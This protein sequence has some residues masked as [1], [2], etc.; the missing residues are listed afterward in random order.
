MH[1]LLPMRTGSRLRIQAPAPTHELSPIAS[2]HGQ[3]M[4][5]SC[6]MRTPDPTSAPKSRRIV[7]LV[8]AG[9]HH[10]LNTSD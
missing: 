10:R 6:R 8:E 3:W 7:A 2:F 5:T 1:V 9:I 4:V